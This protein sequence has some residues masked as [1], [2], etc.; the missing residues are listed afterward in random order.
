MLKGVRE[1]LDRADLLNVGRTDL[2][3]Q[4]YLRHAAGV[5]RAGVHGEVTT[6]LTNSISAFGSLSGGLMR[7]RGGSTSLEAV[8]MVGVRGT[9]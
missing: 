3:L 2:D 8:G 7:M 6:R 4:A 5:T 1:G 9:F